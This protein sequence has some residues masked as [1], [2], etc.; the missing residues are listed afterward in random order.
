MSFFLAI[1]QSKQQTWRM[2]I[3]PRILSLFLTS[4]D[5]FNKTYAL[6]IL[7]FTTSIETSKSPIALARFS[8]HSLPL[9]LL[10]WTFLLILQSPLVVT[11]ILFFDGKCNYIHLSYFYFLCEIFK[12]FSFIFANVSLM[13]LILFLRCLHLHNFCKNKIF[14]IPLDLL[15]YSMHLG[16]MLFLSCLNAC[17]F[18]FFDTE[19]RNMKFSFLNHVNLPIPP[20]LLPWIFL[21]YPRRFILIFRRTPTVSYS[22]CPNFGS[23][24]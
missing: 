15:C 23:I 9:Y 19:I 18:D 17:T 4:F 13:L 21:C 22:I 24:W 1:L 16:F 20:L 3:K 5:K 10:I 6:V 8:V 11:L 14:L 12:I 7:F 2:Y